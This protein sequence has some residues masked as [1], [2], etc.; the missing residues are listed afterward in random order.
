MPP[1]ACLEHLEE[2]RL[3][4]VAAGGAGGHHNVD[5]GHGADTG[6]GGHA[7]GLDD[8]ADLAELSVGEDE[9]DVSDHAGE[10]L[11]AWVFGGVCCVV[12]EVS[13]RAA[14]GGKE[15]KG[16][17]VNEGCRMEKECRRPTM[18]RSTKESS[19]QSTSLQMQQLLSMLALAWKTR[20]ARYAVYLSDA[21]AFRVHRLLAV[22]YGSPSSRNAALRQ[23]SCRE[24]GQPTTQAGEAQTTQRHSSGN[25]RNTLCHTGETHRLQGVAR[26]VLEVEVDDLAHHGVLAH[27]HGGGA[28][29]RETD[30]GHLVRP[31]VVGLNEK[32]QNT[33]R[34]MSLR[35]QTPVINP[36]A[37]SSHVSFEDS[38]GVVALGE[39]GEG[40]RTEDC[41]KPLNTVAVRVAETAQPP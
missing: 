39:K 24:R 26:V 23:G 10:D 16:D 17:D 18:R 4:G 38:A 14:G 13:L 27:E 8:I 1:S 3:S 9:T 33:G 21:S 40:G 28:A 25:T 29:E 2:R 20:T 30:L 7:V 19:L 36:H 12:M 41:W 32:T 34:T 22:V 31:D 6:R 37:N 15:D 5:G 35:M 11:N